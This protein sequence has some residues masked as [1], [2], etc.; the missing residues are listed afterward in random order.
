M[1]ALDQGIF[2]ED[3]EGNVAF[4][5]EVRQED[6]SNVVKALKDSVQKQAALKAGVFLYSHVSRRDK[7]RSSASNHLVPFAPVMRL[8]LI[9]SKSLLELRPFW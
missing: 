4:K 9:S 2:V 7:F 5:E 6:L 3:E 8:T 1:S